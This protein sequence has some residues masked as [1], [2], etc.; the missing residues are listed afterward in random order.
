MRDA[1]TNDDADSRRR[2]CRQ[3]I[4]ERRRR[5]W[6]KRNPQAAL[7]TLNGDVI[8]IR[9]RIPDQLEIPV[10]D[11]EGSGRTAPTAPITRRRAQRGAIPFILKPLPEFQKMLDGHVPLGLALDLAR[12][13]RQDRW[14]YRTR[15]VAK[16][17]D[18]HLPGRANYR[19]DDEGG[20]AFYTEGCAAAALLRRLTGI[21]RAG[22]GEDDDAD[23]RLRA[24]CVAARVSTIISIIMEKAAA[25]IRGVREGNPGK[26]PDEEGEEWYRLVTLKG[27]LGAFLDV[28]EATEWE[29]VRTHYEALV[30]ERE[31]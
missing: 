17:L 20:H 10:H 18:E 13:E 1:E 12:W 11:D 3:T 26:V 5:K 27:E 25:V 6:F 22:G 8:D 15:P 9:P 31:R 30:K 4:A 16:L 7:P 29:A 21:C 23:G 2:R 24:R 28:V 19:D 14:L